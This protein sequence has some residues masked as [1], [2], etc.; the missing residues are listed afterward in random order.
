[1]RP[2]GFPSTLTSLKMNVD[3]RD[4]PCRTTKSMCEILQET[5][6]SFGAFLRRATTENTHR[7]LKCARDLRETTAREQQHENVAR[8]VILDERT[9][10]RSVRGIMVHLCGRL[11]RVSFERELSGN[12]VTPVIIPRVSFDRKH[13]E[14]RAHQMIGLVEERTTH[15]HKQLKVENSTSEK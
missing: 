1:M 13:V 8:T 6:R 12:T 3:T 11:C 9:G 4:R 10:R 14:F 7:T 15:T 2:N 5:F